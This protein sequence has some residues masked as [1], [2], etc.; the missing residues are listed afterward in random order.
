MYNTRPS[1]HQN[2]QASDSDLTSGIGLKTYSHGVM[3]HTVL[4]EDS[5]AKLPFDINTVDLQRM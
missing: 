2:I 4:V 3:I 1:L 5:N